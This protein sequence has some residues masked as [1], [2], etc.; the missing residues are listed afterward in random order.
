MQV[1]LRETAAPAFSALPP[2]LRQA[3]A[4]LVK[5]AAAFMEAAGPLLESFSRTMDE[6]TEQALARTLPKAQPPAP[7]QLAGVDLAIPGN[8]EK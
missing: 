5:A 3:H 8:K 1:S 6:E 7:G 2:N 4:A